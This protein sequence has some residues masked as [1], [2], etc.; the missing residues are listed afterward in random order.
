MIANNKNLIDKSKSYFRWDC[1]P[2]S[3]VEKAK[4]PDSY[5]PPKFAPPNEIPSKYKAKALGFT[6]TPGDNKI[7]P[8]TVLPCLFRLTYLWF[9]NSFALWSKPIAV[10]ES[11]MVCWIWNGNT[12]LLY[13][14]PLYLIECFICL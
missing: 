10:Y 12:W 1:T 3:F 7:A 6:K 11:A 4:S 5:Y 14:I 9:N 2:A 13:N 8:E